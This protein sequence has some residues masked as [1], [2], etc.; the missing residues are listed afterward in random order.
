MTR[1][2]EFDKLEKANIVAAVIIAGVVFVL[3]LVLLQ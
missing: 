1:W 2:S 3:F